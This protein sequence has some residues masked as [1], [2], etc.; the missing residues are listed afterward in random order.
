MNFVKTVL[1]M[2]WHGKE[3]SSR[4][5][6]RYIEILMSSLKLLK[7]KWRDTYWISITEKKR[8]R[9]R[10]KC[11]ICV[12]S[13]SISIAHAFIISTSSLDDSRTKDHQICEDRVTRTLLK[14]YFVSLTTECHSERKHT[15]TSNYRFKGCCSYEFDLSKRCGAYNDVIW[16]FS[17]ITVCCGT[18]VIV[19]VFISIIIC[20]HRRHSYFYIKA[21]ALIRIN[22]LDEPS[23]D[24][25]CKK[26]NITTFFFSNIRL[27]HPQ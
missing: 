20:N 12:T 13:L 17:S 16:F 26:N 1:G 10:E 25:T 14:A 19:V 22:L 6:G 11:F 2:T 18:I 21:S 9:W 3:T 5:Y 15:C 4:K 23:R 7:K 8:S 27:P 24:S